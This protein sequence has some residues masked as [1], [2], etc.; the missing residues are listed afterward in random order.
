MKKSVFIANTIIT[1]IIFSA[2]RKI[3]RFDAVD[4]AEL[5]QSILEANNKN[6]NLIKE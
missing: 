3:R 4:D 2:I 6:K 5:L 1:S